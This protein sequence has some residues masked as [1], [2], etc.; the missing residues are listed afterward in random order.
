[1]KLKNIFLSLTAILIFSIPIF[2]QH[3][4]RADRIAADN[5]ITDQL[6]REGVKY[7]TKRAILWVEKNGLTQKELEEFGTLVNQGILDIEKYTGIK[8]DKKHFQA[9]KMEYFINSKPGISRGTPQNKPFIY[10][11]LVRV[12]EKKAP[13]LHETAHKIAYKSIQ[14]FW[15]QEG[16]ATYIQTYVA[17]RYGGYDTQV[18]NPENVETDQLAKNTLKT[19]AG[20]KLLPLIGLNGTPWSAAISAEQRELYRPIFEDR[21]VTAPA[22]YNLSTSFVKFLIAKL[23]L[24]TLQKVFKSAD[25]KA[26]ILEITGKNVDEWKADWLKSLT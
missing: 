10:L 15:L 6:R 13:Y 18:F 26:D 11:P 14:S 12:K 8:F 4:T 20:K 22:F 9:D 25:T 2:S 3:D 23:G 21:R 19:D 17:R 1:M 7:E 5:A 24:K 16:Y